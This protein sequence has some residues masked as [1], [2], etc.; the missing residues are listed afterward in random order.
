MGGR[1]PQRCVIMYTSVIGNICG[2]WRSKC[3]GIQKLKK[4]IQHGIRFVLP[5]YTLTKPHSQRRF[6]LFPLEGP[7]LAGHRLFPWK[8]K[9]EF[10][11]LFGSIPSL[12]CTF[13]LLFL[14]L[15][16]VF[17]G[18]LLGW[19]PGMGCLKFSCCFWTLPHVIISTK[20]YSNCLFWVKKEARN[21]HS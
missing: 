2:E 4:Q 10:S 18:F 9:P 20:N 5:Y 1:V 8:Q 6:S 16:K 13:V 3:N 17:Q 12:N 21:W 11:P 19:L 7:L 14:S 15:A